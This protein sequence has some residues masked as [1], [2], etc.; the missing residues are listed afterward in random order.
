MT[1]TARIGVACDGVWRGAL[2]GKYLSGGFGFQDPECLDDADTV[3]YVLGRSR[4][5]VRAKAEASGWW[6]GP[7]EGM[8]GLAQCPRCRAAGPVPPASEARR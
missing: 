6:V 7:G 1:V 8:S 4:E 5:D 2:F 3:S